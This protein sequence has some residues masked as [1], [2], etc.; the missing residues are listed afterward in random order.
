MIRASSTFQTKRRMLLKNALNMGENETENAV[1]RRAIA[2]EKVLTKFQFLLFSSF[3]V[4]SIA[5]MYWGNE[6]NER[7]QCGITVH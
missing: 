1:K 5:K 2:E 6:E 3:I 7:I 4:F